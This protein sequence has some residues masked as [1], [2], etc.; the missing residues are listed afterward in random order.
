[1]MY[2]PLMQAFCRLGAC[3]YEPIYGFGDYPGNTSPAQFAL[4]CLFS[5]LTPASGIGYLII[6]LIMQP[7]AYK[8][9]KSWATCSPLLEGEMQDSN[10]GSAREMESSESKMKEIL[11]MQE[12]ELM[13]IVCN[14]ILKDQP[15]GESFASSTD[16]WRFYLDSG[17]I[18]DSD[19][20][21][22]CRDTE[23]I[24]RCSKTVFGVV[25]LEER[26]KRERE[27]ITFAYDRESIVKRDNSLA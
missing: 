23:A 8:L 13:E 27:G 22:S 11:T 17:I 14:P 26:S 9:L 24:D 15:Y 10:N 1:M 19:G 3:I 5:L 21:S 6:F 2:Y 18:S 20:I 16:S 7:N 12:D 25:E 4:G